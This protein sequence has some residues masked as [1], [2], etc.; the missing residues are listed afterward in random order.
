M[1]VNDQVPAAAE[2]LPRLA[3][4]RGCFGACGGYVAA[5]NAF[6]ANAL[7]AAAAAV[8]HQLVA[9][10]RRSNRHVRDTRRNRPERIRALD[11]CD[12]ALWPC[13]VQRWFGGDVLRERVAIERSLSQLTFDGLYALPPWVRRPHRVA[14]WV[15]CKLIIRLYKLARKAGLTA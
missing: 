3:G 4:D 8:N 2:L 6:D 7:H 9:P 12:N 14:L 13:G 15:A 11:L 5:D 10:P 1:N